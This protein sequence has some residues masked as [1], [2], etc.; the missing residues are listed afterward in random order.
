M[1]S[2]KKKFW[3]VFGVILVLLSIF[4]LLRPTIPDSEILVL[5]FASGDVFLLTISDLRKLDGIDF[6]NIGDKPDSIVQVLEGFYQ[7]YRASRGDNLVNVF[8]LEQILELSG[9]ENIKLSRLLFHSS[10]GARVMIAPQGDRDSL[11]L[12][13][14]EREN[15]V[16]TLRLIIPEDGFSQRWL[17]KI[18]RIEVM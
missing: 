1:K 9:L 16:F 2:D 7:R 6:Q 3:V 15:N 10:D 14:L 8:Y 12:M 17:K 11:I 18:V 5:E 13:V 4:L